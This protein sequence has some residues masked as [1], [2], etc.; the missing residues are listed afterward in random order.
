[1]ERQNPRPT[2]RSRPTQKD[3]KVMRIA[4]YGR[5]SSD[6]QRDTSIDDQRRVVLR[7]AQ[8][9]VH[10]VV[11]DFSDAATSGASLDLLQGLQNALKAAFARPA[12]FDALAVDQLS[13]LS[14]DVGDTDVIV[15]R[16]RF[17][18]VRVIA[19]SD[20]I[21]TGNDTM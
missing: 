21:D 5:Y 10:Q 13:R 2:D 14:R 18:G 1:M 3:R 9:Q 11:S 16:L 17:V 12:P 20:G 15:K 19:V 8:A 7:W 4:F 6:N